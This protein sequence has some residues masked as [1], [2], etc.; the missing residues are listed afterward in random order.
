MLAAE[1][2]LAPASGLFAAGR[3]IYASTSANSPLLGQ[4]LGIRLTSGGRGNASFDKI[5]LNATPTVVSSSARQIASGGGWKTTLTIINLTATPNVVRLA[6]RGDDGRP[7]TLPLTVTHQGA[8]L[9]ATAST[10]ERTVE[11][12]G[13][14]LIE[15]EAPITSATLAG[16]AE[17]VRAGPISGFAIFRQRGPDGRAAEGTAP[18]ESAG[19]PS[20][21]LPFDNSAG[22]AT[23]VA[24]VN[25]TA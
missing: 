20:L 9:P 18:L 8:S 10:V 21:T 5:S 4:R 15:S 6:F 16:W 12:G 23:G 11:P 22:L 3:I 25:A 13:T 24:P 19:T 1:S 17:V 14:L 2:S 7:L